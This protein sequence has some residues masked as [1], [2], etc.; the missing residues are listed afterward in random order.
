MSDP[1]LPEN[2]GDYKLKAARRHLDNLIRLE[3]TAGSLAAGKVRIEAEED[4]DEYLYH[5][6]GVKDALLQEI[7]NELHLDLAQRDANLGAINI[8]LNQR[9]ADA[10][11]ITKE[12]DDMLSNEHNPLWLV[13]ELHNHSKH[14]NLI[15]QAIV[16]E[17]GRLAR[18]SLIDPRTGEEMRTADDVRMR[19]L[20]TFYLEESYTGIEDLQRTV[21]EKIRQYLNNNST[22][23]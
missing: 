15:G 17:N 20:A 8:K 4:I 14:R 7:N 12:I 21:R 16:I 9:G 11:A 23:A 13:N 1:N 3:D 19:I 18:A 5:L 2:R 6:I 22:E 10:R